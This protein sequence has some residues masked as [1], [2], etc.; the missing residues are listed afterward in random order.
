[1]VSAIRKALLTLM[2]F[3]E[4]PNHAIYHT[5]RKYRPESSRPP[6]GFGREL[7]NGKVDLKETSDYIRHDR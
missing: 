3:E 1:M 5:A 6:R 2:R 7:G 4:T